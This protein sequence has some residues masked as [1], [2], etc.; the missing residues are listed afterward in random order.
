MVNHDLTVALSLQAPREI[1]HSLE[2]RYAGAMERSLLDDV[3]LL[4]SEVVTNAVQHSGRPDGDPVTLESSVVD[5]VLRVEI[6]D[7]GQ[8]VIRLEP[9]ATDPP[10]GL[11]YVEILSDR[12]SSRLND[13]FH[14][15]F[16]ID[17][18]SHMT[19]YRRV[20]AG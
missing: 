15:W 13:S 1:R 12:W 11:G 6:T 10:S 9:R 19:V 2:A 14:V 20:A 16:E 17:V 5:G 4:A 7:E 8:G 18:A 3:T